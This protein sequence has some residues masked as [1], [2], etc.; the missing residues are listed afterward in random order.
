MRRELS[1]VMTAEGHSEFFIACSELKNSKYILA[2]NKITAL[3]KTIADNKQLYALFS[4]ALYGFDYSATFGECV[5]DNTFTLPS[6]KKTAIAMVFRILMDIDT[7]RMTLR[8][9]LEAYFYS[10][11]MNESFARFVLEVIVPFETYCKVYLLEDDSMSE[12]NLNTVNE[13]YK[14]ELKTGA[15]GCLASLIE[16]GENAITTVY[17][18]TE[19]VACLNGLVRSLKADDLDN[20]VSSFLGVKYAISYF[21]KS[22]TDVAQIFKKLDYD[23][24]H[25]LRNT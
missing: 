3:L 7:G 8:N 13:K 12:N 22:D 14:I 25:L 1:D 5:T 18:R 21:F 17:D 11:S 16:Y 2:E 6:D 20:I 15:L 23:V 9:F 19:Y 10:D 24:K 4:A